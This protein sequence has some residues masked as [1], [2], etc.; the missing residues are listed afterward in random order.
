MRHS[1]GNS[2]D[3]AGWMCLQLKPNIHPPRTGLEAT[4][5]HALDPSSLPGVVLHGTS[6]VV[7]PSPGRK[8][9]PQ[10]EAVMEAGPE[11]HDLAQEYGH[12]GEQRGSYCS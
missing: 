3:K 8:S 12:G 1:G 9:V 6:W 2:S 11:Q 7:T 5:Q 4:F 10:D